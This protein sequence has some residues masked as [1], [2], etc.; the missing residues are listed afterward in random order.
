MSKSVG[1]PNRRKNLKIEDLPEELRAQLGFV[2]RVFSQQI[3]KLGEKFG[4]RLESQIKVSAQ[5]IKEK[6]NV[7]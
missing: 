7:S 6:E 1:R 3:T 5:K 4:V 2:A